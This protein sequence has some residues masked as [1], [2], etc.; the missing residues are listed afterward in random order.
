[1]K[2]ALYEEPL[3]HKF[4]F[5]PLPSRFVDGDTLL[6]VASDRWFESHAEAIAALPELL[7]S[8]GAR[9][10]IEWSGAAK[11]SVGQDRSRTS[12]RK[13]AA[14]AEVERASTPVGDP[15]CAIGNSSRIRSEVR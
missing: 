15:R 7:E 4:A 13:M 8:G 1:M 3:T 11:V 5:F 2:Y 6:T 10:W 14:P 12:V 9:A